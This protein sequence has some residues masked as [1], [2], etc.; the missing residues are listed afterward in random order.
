MSIGIV[1]IGIGNLGS[2]KSAIYNIGKD[3]LDVSSPKDLS[4]ITHLILPGVGSFAVAMEKLEQAHL[5][6]PIKVFAKEG[7]PVFGICL[8][9]QLFATRGVEGGGCDG[10]DLVPGQIEPMKTFDNLRSPHI[11]W[12]EVIQRSGHPIFEGIRDN[13][14]F[15][16]VHGYRFNVA[17]D[18]H[19]ISETDYGERF[20]SSIG[21]RNIVG[22]QF[23]PEKSQL[24]GIRLLE[25]FCVWDGVC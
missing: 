22:V 21:F 4:K 17:N 5:I 2:V 23:H 6:D 9:M 11:G 24:N 3:C 20:P 10:L 25:N 12:N 15:Y 8:G 7:R 18:E 1:N 16:F 14:D 19:I 13:V